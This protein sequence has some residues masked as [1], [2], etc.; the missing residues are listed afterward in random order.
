MLADLSLAG[1]K[2]PQRIVA[3]LLHAVD[4]ELRH[5]NDVRGVVPAWL[6]E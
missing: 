2:T 4:S 3:L 5:E 1:C 6:G